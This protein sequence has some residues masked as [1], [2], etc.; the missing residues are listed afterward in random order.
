MKAVILRTLAVCLFVL[1]TQFIHAQAVITEYFDVK[2]S[3][4]LDLQDKKISKAVYI[5]G[6]LDIDW[7]SDK[8]VL[9]I[10]YDPKITSVTEVMTN[11]GNQTGQTVM[12]ANNAD[13]K[14]RNK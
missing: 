12:S 14:K 3:F 7:N 5:K 11:I 4:R 13:K 9:A 8:R 1:S 2:E 6:V 10:S